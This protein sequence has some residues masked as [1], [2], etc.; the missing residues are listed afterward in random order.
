MKNIVYK[1]TF[2]MNICLSLFCV[3][4]L[5]I[6][7]FVNIDYVEVKLPEKI[8]NIL[9]TITPIL[10]AISLYRNDQGALL[11]LSLTLNVCVAIIVILIALRS[12]Y[13]QLWD[14]VLPMLIWITPCIVNLVQL[15]KNPSYE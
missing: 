1:K 13:H 14:A 5:L 11:K 9:F 15:S 10:T 2:W 4:G 8:I 7:F 3:L 6:F 12:F